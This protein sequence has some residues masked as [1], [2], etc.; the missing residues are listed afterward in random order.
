MRA[1]VI[2]LAGSEYSKACAA[3]CI[4]TAETVGRLTVDPFDATTADDAEQVLRHHGLRWTWTQD[5]IRYCPTTG[6]RMHP[7]KGYA[8][9]LGCAMSHFRLWLDCADSAR[10]AMVLEHDAVFLREFRPFE[11]MSACQLN[12]PR[13]A[14]RRGDWW[15]D[16]MKARG[17]GVFPKTWVTD[18]KDRIPDGLA[19]NSAYVLQPAT[20]ERLIDLYRTVG[21]WPN[22]AT[23]CAQLVPDLEEC[24][25][26]LT[27]VQQTC[28][29]TS[30]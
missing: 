3:R 8:A 1:F 26:F 12:D 5:D 17:P 20:A 2:R 30:R 25:P 6:L 19:G 16:R 14:T 27:E 13:G 7:Y 23:L 9:R 11:F 21:V 15:S 22:D 4:A 28:S 29:T 18:P 24:Y 10:P